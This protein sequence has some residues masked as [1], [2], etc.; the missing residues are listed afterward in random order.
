MTIHSAAHFVETLRQHPLLESA[1]K[2]ELAKL[3][4]QFADPKGLA[5]EMMQRGWITPYQIN[6]VFQGRAGDLVLGPYIIQ[7][8]V[9]EGGMGAVFKARHQRL[10][11]VVALKVIRKQHMTRPDSSVRFQREARAAAQLAHPNIVGVYDSD[12]AGGTHYLAMEY[13]EGIDLARLVK[14]SGPLPIGQ[15]CEYIRQAALGLQHAHDNGLVHRDIKPSNL[16]VARRTP[17]DTPV[18]KILDFGLARFTS[19]TVEDGQLTDT[20][21]VMG[22]P[23][24][25]APEQAHNTRS[26]DIRAD[27]FSL[28][29]SLFYLLTGQ[30]PFAGENVME[31]L[32]ARISGQSRSVWELRPEVPPELAA[33]VTKMIA[34]KPEDRYQVPADVAVAL[35]P[36]CTQDDNSYSIPYASALHTQ[37]TFSTLPSANGQF[38][39]TLQIQ[40]QKILKHPHRKYIAAGVVGAMVLFGFVVMF[41]FS[42]SKKTSKTDDKT[43]VQA[44]GPVEDKAPDIYQSLKLANAQLGKGPYRAGDPLT[45]TFELANTGTTPLTIPEEKGGKPGEHSAGVRQTWIERLG[46]DPTIPIKGRRQGRKYAV[47]ADSFLVDAVVPVG[48]T[49]RYTAIVKTEGFTAGVYRYSIELKKPG[50]DVAHTENVEFELK[51]GSVS[52]EESRD[53]VHAALIGKQSFPLEAAAWINGTPLTAD[54]VKGKVVLLDFWA[55][56]CPPCIAIQP[57]LRRWHEKYEKDG[58]VLVSMTRYFGVTWD[59]QAKAPKQVKGLSPQ[60]EEA[61]HVQFAKHHNLHH[62][63][64]LMPLEGDLDQRYGVTAIPQLVL[65]DRHGKIRLIRVGASPANLRAFEEMIEKLVAEPCPVEPAR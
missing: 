35:A 58:L 29:C 20:G 21:Q 39:E 19:E 53:R 34:M 40:V 37:A 55:M 16:V 41:A 49:Y 51:P 9:G 64:G 44:P 13:V 26:A 54:S 31:K 30:V 18:V 10:A 50:G 27:I 25:I 43:K 52:P 48:K 32:A 46:D 12:Q 59:A 6:Q 62:R 56:W 63:V 22:T 4:E 17:G 2:D 23:D 15:G 7:E 65:I 57:T 11:R 24:Y 28:G 60:D 1:P 42:G 5:R 45:F 38:A 3:V 33:V 47:G 36:Y 8:R 14:Q 61:A